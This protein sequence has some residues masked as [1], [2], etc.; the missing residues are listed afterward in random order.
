[1]TQAIFMNFTI[2]ILEYLI[3]AKIENLSNNEFG[4]RVRKLSKRVQY[5][6]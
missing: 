6:A 2:H 1:M 5:D 4:K 3:Q